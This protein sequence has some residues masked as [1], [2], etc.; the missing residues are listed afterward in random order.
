MIRTVTPRDIWYMRNRPR[1]Q[2]VF[3][4]DGTLAEPHQPFWYA[5]RGLIEG[6]SREALT[7]VYR[8]RVLRALAQTSSRPGRPEHDLLL[9]AS[10]G[11]QAPLPTDR[12]LWFRLLE[13]LCAHVGSFGV[14]RIYTALSQRHDELHETFR[15]NGFAAYGRQTVMMLDGPDWDQGTSVALMRALT[16]RD[17]WAV[18]RLYGATTPHAVQRAEP[19]APRDW[20]P[21]S[22][23]GWRRPTQRAWVVGPESELTGYLRVV[24]GSAAHVITPVV[25]PEARDTLPEYL[26]FGLSQ[27]TDTLPVYLI[28]RQYQ[29]D[30]H[31]PAEALG[32]ST[33]GE[34]MLLVRSMTVSVRGRIAVP[35]VEAHAESR[36]PIPTISSISEDARR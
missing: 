33:I 7:L 22:G 6:Y 36:H 21:S 20:S 13:A 24:S 9:L 8:D 16:R 12:D 17:V 29:E 34:Q 11:S 28:L 27:I 32:F 5:M 19:H 15:Q 23:R 31:A 4:T 30:L 25:R 26:R 2:A 35:S 10:Y 3:Y 14:Q 1:G 18:H